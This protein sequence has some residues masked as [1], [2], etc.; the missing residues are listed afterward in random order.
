M[1][2]Y[3]SLYEGIVLPIIALQ[4]NIDLMRTSPTGEGQ[5]K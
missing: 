4:A 1:Q 2:V 5:Y 3:A